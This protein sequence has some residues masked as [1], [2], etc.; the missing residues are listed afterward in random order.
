MDTPTSTYEFIY[1]I[2]LDGGYGKK[3][4]SGCYNTLYKAP[5][6]LYTKSTPSFIYF[7]VRVL[8]EVKEMKLTKVQ[9]LWLKIG[10]IPTSTR[11][12]KWMK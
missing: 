5:P 9:K 6:P 4:A 8:I 1:L 10:R 3:K 7:V 11:R 12:S 2:F